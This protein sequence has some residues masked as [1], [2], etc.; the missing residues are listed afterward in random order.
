[1]FHEVQSQKKEEA[2]PNFFTGNIMCYLVQS[3]K[4][5]EA[6]PNILRALY[7]FS[8]IMA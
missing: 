8:A 3:Q 2:V 6:V 4:R 1:M 5:V 7:G